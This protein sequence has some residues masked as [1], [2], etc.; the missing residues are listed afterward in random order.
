MNNDNGARSTPHWTTL[1]EVQ[2]TLGEGEFGCVYLARDLSNGSQVAI[3]EVPLPRVLSWGRHE[4]KRM[5]LEA[6]LLQKV[7]GVPGVIELYDCFTS[8]GN[9]Y[10]VME[11]VP[12]ATSLYDHME[13]FGKLPIKDVKRLFVEIVQTVHR[14]LNSGVSHKDLKPENILLYEDPSTGQLRTKLI[15]FGCG[16]RVKSYKGTDTG[17]TMIYL[18]PE[19]IDGGDF[20]HV[21]ATVWSLGTLLYYLVCQEDP[22]YDEDDIEKAKPPFPQDVPP[23]CRKLIMRCFARDP[24]KRPTLDGIV[25]H[26]WLKGPGSGSQIEPPDPKL[27]PSKV[28][29]KMALQKDKK[30][31]G[32][33]KETCKTP[34]EK[35]ANKRSL[36]EAKG[37][38]ENS[39]CTSGKQKKQKKGE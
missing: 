33:A 18:P 32:R 24:W 30:K 9:F 22:F 26:P 8:D 21:P 20:L 23:S 36:S 16:E 6:I 29:K 27:F 31:N 17:G 4:G 12:K 15:D 10:M 5:P 3:K 13:K 1:F 14:C 34:K 35:N 7:Q 37:A 25:R 38:S 2:D 11:L 19:Y 39:G 28:L